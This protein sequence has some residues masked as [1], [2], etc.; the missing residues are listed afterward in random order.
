ML[1]YFDLIFVGVI[2]LSLLVYVLVPMIRD[3]RRHKR[4]MNAVNM[5]DLKCNHTGNWERLGGGGEK[6]SGFVYRCK[7]C[8]AIAIE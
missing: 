2:V 3:R 5:F 7:K 8:G 6:D 1:K 4:R